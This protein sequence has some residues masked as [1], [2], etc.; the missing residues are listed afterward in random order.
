[1][2]KDDK[3]SLDYT[4]LLEYTLELEAEI[5]RLESKLQ[6]VY[7]MVNLSEEPNNKVEQPSVMRGYMNAL[8]DLKRILKDE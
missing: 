3:N 6:L 5:M 8:E 1:M 2:K 4:Q 7:S